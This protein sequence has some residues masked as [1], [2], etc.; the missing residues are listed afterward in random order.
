MRRR[1]L[2]I[3]LVALAVVVPGEASG[4]VLADSNEAGDAVVL[5]QVLTQ[6]TRSLLAASRTAKGPFGQARAISRPSFPE[7]QDVGVDEA[8]DAVLAWKRIQSPYGRDDVM[9]SFK[10]KGGDAVIAWTDDAGTTRYSFRPAGGAFGG[11]RPIPATKGRVE[12]VLDDGGGLLALWSPFDHAT[13]TYTLR[14]EY[15]P[16]GGS[17]G[18][19]SEIAGPLP[20]QGVY[21]TRVATDRSGN[22][23]FAWRARTTIRVATR[24]A[25]ASSLGAPQ[26]VATGLHGRGAVTDMRDIS[27]GVS[28]GWTAGP[29]E[30]PAI[31]LR[32]NG[33]VAWVSC[34]GTDGLEDGAIVAC[35]KGT[36]A[37]KRVYVLGSRAWRP[38]LAGTSRQIDPLSL[39][40]GGSRLT[41]RDGRTLRS[42]RL[43]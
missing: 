43:R 23:V 32:P 11:A 25:G 18:A 1:I 31:R 26:T 36:H 15:K 12:L 2:S 30:V 3:V 13:K 4:R 35:K 6:R 7:G 14:T 5:E 17:F 9:V 42:T 10:P 24:T 22:A 19:V 37:R 38:R 16:A 28:R 21:D 29:A 41:W 34:P 40:L 33:A 39:A 27:D 20:S 8:G